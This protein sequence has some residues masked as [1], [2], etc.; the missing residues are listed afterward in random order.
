MPTLLLAVKSGIGIAPLPLAVGENEPDLQRLLD[1]IPGV[2]TDFYLLM[3][4]DMRETP[5]VR[6][7]FDFIVDE[8]KVVRAVLGDYSE[9]A[10]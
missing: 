7:F 1:P 5:R 9:R 3:H 8:L 10:P 2:L 4:E 6:A